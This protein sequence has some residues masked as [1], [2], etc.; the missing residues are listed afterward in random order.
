[1]FVVHIK[2]FSRVPI[3]DGERNNIIGL[4]FI[5]ELALVDPQ[6][7]IPLKTLCRFYKNQCNFIFEDTTLV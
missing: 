7:A 2:G 6:D 3:Y 4:L 5:K 1:L